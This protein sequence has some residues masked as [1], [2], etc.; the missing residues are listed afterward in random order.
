[1][2]GLVC[3]GGVMATAQERTAWRWQLVAAVCVAS[4]QVVNVAI[5]AFPAWIP[6]TLLAISILLGGSALRLLIRDRQH[7]AGDGSG[8]EG[9]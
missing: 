9:R 4:A 3:G 1:M 5:G 7:R 8:A 6:L 2:R